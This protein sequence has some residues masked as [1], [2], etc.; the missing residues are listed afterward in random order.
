ML[1]K[2]LL[3]SVGDRIVQTVHP[4][5]VSS[6]WTLQMWAVQMDS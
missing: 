2:S 6:D 1:K 4:V 5:Q 3:K